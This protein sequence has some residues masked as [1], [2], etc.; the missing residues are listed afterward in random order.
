MFTAKHFIN[1]ISSFIIGAVSL[2]FVY[3]YSLVHFNRPLLLA[4][5]YALLF[6]F[7]VLSFDRIKIIPQW[8]NNN[9]YFSAIILLFFSLLLYYMF[10]TSKTDN[11][12]GMLAIR[13]WLDNF[14]EGTFP[15]RLKNTFRA[16][17]FFYL[18]ASP[19][20]LIGNIS[21]MEILIW[22]IIAFLV[23]FNSETVREKIIKLFFLLVS[24]ITFYGLFK[25]S[26]YFLNAS[27]L[28]ILFLLSNRY[29][30][31]GK[32]DRNFI[33]LAVSFGLF[34]SI[35]I[36]II[37]V[38]IIY[39]L[40]FFRNNI[41]E[42]S[43]FLEIL[44]AVFLVTIIPF[45]VW[46]PFLFFING[47]LNTLFNIQWWGIILYLGIAVYIGWMIS[48]LQEIFFSIG[49]LLIIPCVINLFFIKDDLSG[50]IIALP[51]FIFSIK[52]YHIEKFA[53]KILMNGN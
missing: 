12:F 10:F 46:N 30:K 53:G 45:I 1:L 27:I 15:Y 19:F 36:E 16:Y 5:I 42:L 14:F 6:L 38:L 2:I 9:R 25:A 41:K 13:N 17:P 3:K 21:L 28:I 22:V 4:L 37:A 47:P 35:N 32:V 34:F 40:Y 50:F 7:V 8:L 49:L 11:S 24:P 44:L 18:L 39:M 26:G 48:D 51:F 31:P 29:I 23:V 33:L 43:L 52:D 20:Y